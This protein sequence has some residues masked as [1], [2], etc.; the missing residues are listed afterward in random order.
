MANGSKFIEM[1][2]SSR[3][4]F[5]LE[6]EEWDE[7]SSGGGGGG[8]SST[9][10]GLTDVDIANPTDG[11]TLVY[12]ATSGKWENGAGGVLVIHVGET[13]AMDKTWQEIHDALAA[14]VVMVFTYAPFGDGEIYMAFINAAYHDVDGYF[15][16]AIS[17][18]G[19]NTSILFAGCA[20]ADEYPILSD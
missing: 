12:N 3:Y 13:G 7:W 18:Q 20:S 14:G 15:V 9:L 6:D 1:D 2:T 16:A 8:G 4:L 11:Q 5:N 19:P 17:T 10:A